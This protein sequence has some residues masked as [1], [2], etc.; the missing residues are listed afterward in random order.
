MKGE[1]IFGMKRDTKT[2]RAIEIIREDFGKI[3]KEDL[4][5][6]AAEGTALKYKEVKKIYDSIE[7]MLIKQL[8]EKNRRA[9]LKKELALSKDEVI[10]YK[11]KLRRKFIFDDSKLSSFGCN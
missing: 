9:R 4:I 3:I 5:W 10:T 7:K 8:A 2:R 1:A 6:K 11:G